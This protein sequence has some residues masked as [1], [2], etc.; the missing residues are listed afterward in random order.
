MSIIRTTENP[1]ISKIGSKIRASVYKKTSESVFSKRMLRS[2]STTGD[3]I[4]NLCRVINVLFRMNSHR[5]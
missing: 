5:C 1:K 4:Y 2:P 3:V